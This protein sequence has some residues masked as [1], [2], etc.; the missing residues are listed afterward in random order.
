MTT[1][2]LRRQ[3][4]ATLAMAG[5]VVLGHAAGAS[6][7]NITTQVRFSQLDG[8]ILDQDHCVNGVFEA[9][10]LTVKS[11]GAIIID[12]PSARFAVH[13]NV[14]I[15]NSG[16]IRMPSIIP[17]DSGPQITIST[18]GNF[19][20]KNDALIRSHGRL[21][22]GRIIIMALGDFE[23]TQR[24]KIEAHNAALTVIAGTIEITAHGK[25]RLVNSTNRVTGN[26]IAGGVVTLCSGSPEC[27]AIYINGVVN[28]VGHKGPGGHVMIRADAGGIQTV[29]EF[30]RIAASGTEGPGTITFF[31]DKT[32]DPAMPMTNPPATVKTNGNLCSP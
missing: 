23:M 16:A 17:G 15:E 10:D 31:A 14:V 2:V 29:G 21:R 26:G 19:L 11:T 30:F 27:P 12:V 7:L 1:R 8:S 5:M 25:I 20:M 4:Y 32:I 22:G 9:A 13:G 18:F 28:A 24:A 3:R 6:A